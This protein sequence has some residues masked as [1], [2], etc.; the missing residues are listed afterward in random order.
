MGNNISVDAYVAELEAAV[1]ALKIAEGKSFQKIIVEDALKVIYALNR[2]P[3]AEKWQGLLLL[4]IGRI[5]AR[6]LAEK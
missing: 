5:L 4:D 6:N 1:L 2:D 3:R